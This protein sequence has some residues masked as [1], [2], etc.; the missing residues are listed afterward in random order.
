MGG[1]LEA[2]G[3]GVL[4]VKLNFLVYA[5]FLM[6]ANAVT[7]KWNQE[8][9]QNIFLRGFWRK[10][11]LENV[12]KPKCL[13]VS[14]CQES[15]LTL[16][17]CQFVEK[18]TKKE[19]LYW[20]IVAAVTGLKCDLRGLDQPECNSCSSASFLR[21]WILPADHLHLHVIALKPDKTDFLRFQHRDKFLA[22]WDNGRGKF[23]FS[24]GRRSSFFT[25]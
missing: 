17:I 1:A 13:L 18:T 25:P 21:K 6:F 12:S 3:S 10:K 11:S 24:S 5:G 20:K 8:S 2:D 14:A 22:L 19:Q 7:P 23:C 9:F 16:G 4:K 15:F